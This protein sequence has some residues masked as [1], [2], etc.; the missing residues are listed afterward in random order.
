MYAWLTASERPVAQRFYA[1][2]ASMSSW[3]ERLRYGW[4]S[5]FPSADYMRQRYGI[6]NALFVPL[7]YPYRWFL[8]L[9]SALPALARPRKPAG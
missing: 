4:G 2:L 3:R 1:D 6:S 9:K 8:G 7:S 5:V